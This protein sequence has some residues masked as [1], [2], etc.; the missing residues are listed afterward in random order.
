[1]ELCLIINIW[2]FKISVS[3][4]KSLEKIMRNI[5]LVVNVGLGWVD[6]GKVLT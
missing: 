3:V 5:F 6:A 1:M 2:L 4:S